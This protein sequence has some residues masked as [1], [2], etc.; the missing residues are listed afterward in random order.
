MRFNPMTWYME[1]LRDFVLHGNYNLTLY[2]LMVPVMTLLV[3]W[4]SLRF[5]RRF[6]THFED[7]L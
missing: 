3:F 1:R 4:L 7:F 5:F 2:D 6:A